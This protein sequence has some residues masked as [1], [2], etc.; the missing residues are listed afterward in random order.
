MV[1]DLFR[2]YALARRAEATFQWVTIAEGVE[3]Q[4]AEVFDPVRMKE[5]YEIGYEVARAGPKWELQP[6][7]F[8]IE[9]PAP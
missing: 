9:Q 7:A 3:L 6:P 4:G 8:R 1:G 5:L 2:E